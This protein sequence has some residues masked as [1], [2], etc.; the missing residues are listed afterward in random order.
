MRYMA[1]PSISQDALKAKYVEI[2][3]GLH[4]LAISYLGF[5]ATEQSGNTDSLVD[6]DFCV[7]MKVLVLKYLVSCST[8]MVLSSERILPRYLKLLTVVYQYQ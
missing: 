3:Q 1:T 4:V 7:Q 5:T 6:T 2:L 8:S